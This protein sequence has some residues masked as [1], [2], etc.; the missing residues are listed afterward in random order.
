M[1]WGGGPCLR[2]RERPCLV[3][4]KP[5][6]TADLKPRPCTNATGKSPFARG[7]GS[8]RT[9]TP[10]PPAKHKCPG[11][12]RRGRPSLTLKQTWTFAM[13]THRLSGTFGARV[14]N[15]R[16]AERDGLDI[17]KLSWGA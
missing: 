16:D 8:R 3:A 14:L 7:R 13:F 11:E 6:V 5:C 9:R 12:E 4:R 17:H 15:V 10:K 1:G 2:L